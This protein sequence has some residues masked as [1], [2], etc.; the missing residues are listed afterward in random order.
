MIQG[1]EHTAIA[2]LDPDSLAG[3]YV[4]TLDFVVE[5]HNVAT[6]NFFIRSPDG[7][8]IEVIWA[9]QGT[10]VAE[11]KDSG[12]RHMAMITNDFD[13]DFA[14]LKAAGAPLLTEPEVRG[15]NRVVF[16]R[17]PDGNILHLI[18]RPVPLARP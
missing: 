12:M 4:K 16:F 15:G 2:S 18:Q 8:R 17:D 6:R 13:A 10:G 7:S 9:T 3:W 11:M 1:I 14:R 5:D